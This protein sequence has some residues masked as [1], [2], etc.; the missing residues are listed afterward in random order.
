MSNYWYNWC[1]VCLGVGKIKDNK[2]GWWA[3]WDRVI[4]PHC[5]GSCYEPAPMT[6]HRPQAPPP[7]PPKRYIHEDF[8]GNKKKTQYP[9][10]PELNERIEKLER[11]GEELKTLVY[12]LTKFSPPEIIKVR[13]CSFCG[14][15]FVKRTEGQIDCREC[16]MD[17]I[18]RNKK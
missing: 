2:S 4:C 10:S 16:M 12:E 3:V 13:R 7:P 8:G 11:Q 18:E 9:F 1:T 5:S 14:D 6:T 17:K 15:Y